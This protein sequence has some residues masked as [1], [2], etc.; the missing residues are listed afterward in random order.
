MGFPIDLT[1]LFL[2]SLSLEKSGSDILCLVAPL[3]EA[4]LLGGDLKLVA[5]MPAPSSIVRRIFS[6]DFD[7]ERPFV[8]R[9]ELGR[10]LMANFQLAI[11]IPELVAELRPYEAT[12]VVG[13][14]LA[15]FS[16][17]GQFDF[18]V[19]RYLSR[20]LDDEDRPEALLDCVDDARLYRAAVVYDE[21]PEQ[22][23]AAIR[24]LADAG[25]VSF[26]SRNALDSQPAH[27]FSRTLLSRDLDDRPP[28]RTKLTALDLACA[29]Y[30]R[31][32]PVRDFAGAVADLNRCD[33]DVTEASEFLTFLS[34]KPNSKV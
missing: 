24:P 13:F 17:V 7:G 20:Q 9:L 8:R 23:A 27:R 19:S 18:Q 30:L 6:D 34:T 12:G 29:A 25:L 33:V 28:W 16:Q 1:D 2:L 11:G 3:A 32:A 31:A 10:A 15:R 21:T 4:R 14:N 5:G 26:D 22:I